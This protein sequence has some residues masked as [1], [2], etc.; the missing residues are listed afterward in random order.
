MD[1]YIP[2]LLIAGLAS[3]GMAFMPAVAKRT[4][5][6]YSLIYI[7]IGAIT[8]LVVGDWLPSP[9]PASNNE[10]T[11][12][13]TELIVIVSLM[14]TGIKIDRGFSFRNWSSPLRLI[15]IA[16]VLCILACVLMGMLMLDLAL[17]AALL[18]GA[19]LVP[20]DP[21]LASDVQV[22]PPNEKLK[23]EAKFALTSEAGLNDGFAFPFT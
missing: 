17:P 8:Y 11:V 7:A 5:I 9:L 15:L 4:G 20:T 22:G 3:L 6:S 13:L 21:V 16:M 14:G 1:H 23:S 12:H 19:V 10:L 2:V 18:L